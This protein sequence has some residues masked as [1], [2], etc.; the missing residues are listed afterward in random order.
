MKIQAIAKQLV[1][2]CRKAQWETAQK[3]LYAVN[4][5]STEAEAGPGG[6]KETKGRKAIIAKG[7]E[8]TAMTEKVYALKVSDPII[9]DEYFACTMA[10]D[11]KM[12]GQG[13]IKMSELCVYQVKRGKIVS[14]HFHY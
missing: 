6:K 10:I 4:A 8:F 11:M 7:R 12:K 2:L 13:R 5:T 1:A 9:A 3:K 14:E